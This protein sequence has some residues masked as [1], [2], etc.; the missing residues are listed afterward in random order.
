MRQAARWGELLKYRM[1][2]LQLLSLYST[3]QEYTRYPVKQRE[4]PY[5]PRGI[6]NI[7]VTYNGIPGADSARLYRPRSDGHAAPE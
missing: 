6:W 4:I 7:L 2:S 3:S 5:G 1:K